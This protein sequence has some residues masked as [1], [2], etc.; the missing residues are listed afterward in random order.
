MRLSKKSEYALR[1]LICLSRDPSAMH[2]IPA[3]SRSEKI[4]AKFLEQ[5][6]LTLR[7]ANLVSSRRGAGGGYFLELSPAKLRVWDVVKVMEEFPAPPRPPSRSTDG[8]Y[9]VLDAYLG[10]LSQDL[11]ELLSTT[12]LED[13]IKLEQHSQSSTFDI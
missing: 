11:Q 8:G 10:K 4:P 2:T 12:S 3:I 7:H 1:A 5:I 6:L 13:L 9:S